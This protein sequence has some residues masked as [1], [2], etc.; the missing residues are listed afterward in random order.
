MADARVLV[1]PAGQRL[2][3]VPGHPM[4][5]TPAPQ[6]MEPCLNDLNLKNIQPTD[7]RWDRMVGIELRILDLGPPRPLLGPKGGRRT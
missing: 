6:C 5:L 1:P 2:H 3:P 4:S 7:V